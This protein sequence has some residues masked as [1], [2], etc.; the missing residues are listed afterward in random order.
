MAIE[1]EC[2]HA[3]TAR[4]TQLFG[5]GRPTQE[6]VNDLVVEHGRNRIRDSSRTPMMPVYLADLQ[7]RLARGAALQPK[8]CMISLAGDARHR[9]RKR[10]GMAA[11]MR[12]SQGGFWPGS[13][14]RHSASPGHALGVRCAGR[15]VRAGRDI[16]ESQSPWGQLWGFLAES[17]SLPVTILSGSCQPPN[18]S[19]CCGS[20][21]TTACPLLPGNAHAWPMWSSNWWPESQCASFERRFPFSRSMPKVASIQGHSKSS[22]L[23]SR[24]RSL[25][26]SSPHPW[27]RASNPSLTRPR[28]SLRKG[29]N[30]F[31]HELWRARSMRRRWGNDGAYACR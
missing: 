23:R 26:P 3:W 18:S 11:F 30:G 28:D 22:N 7:R 29:A 16:V 14:L 9:G 31:R 20:R 24:S 5:S 19:G 2:I 15:T 12:G 8:T 27:M 6:D 17:F 21:P 25:P 10:H 1:K 13:D 4:R